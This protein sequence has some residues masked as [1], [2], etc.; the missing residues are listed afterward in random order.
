MQ[1]IFRIQS[2]HGK[3]VNSVSPIL[4]H[5]VNQKVCARF[6]FFFQAIFFNDARHMCSINILSSRTSLCSMLLPRTFSHF[7]T[8]VKDFVINFAFMNNPNSCFTVLLGNEVN[9]LFSGFCRKNGTLGTIQCT[10]GTIRNVMSKIKL[11]NS[12]T[13]IFTSNFLLR[14]TESLS[15]MRVHSNN[16]KLS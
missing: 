6:Q 4:H 11:C 15:V 13:T 9:P 3:V 7:V 10:S 14:L 1:Q 2:I 12:C 5:G 16:L 8:A